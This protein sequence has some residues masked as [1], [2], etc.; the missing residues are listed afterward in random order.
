[1]AGGSYIV[2]KPK[3]GKTRK[4]SRRSEDHFGAKLPGWIKPAK[5]K[6]KRGGFR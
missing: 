2:K 3:P 6:P 4:A 1:M 5:E